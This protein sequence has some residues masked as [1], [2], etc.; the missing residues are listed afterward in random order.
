MSRS[1]SG[2]ERERAR[3]TVEV[4]AQMRKVFNWSLSDSCLA[5]LLTSRASISNSIHSTRHRQESIKRLTKRAPI[6][7]IPFNTQHP[8]DG[9]VIIND[10]H[11]TSVD[12]KAKREKEME[13]FTFPENNTTIK[14]NLSKLIFH[15]Y[16]PLIDK[17][18]YW[19]RCKSIISLTGG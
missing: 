17:S 10:S 6:Y 19:Q 3:D 4:V 11:V 9:F 14:K 2:G 12:M 5:W 15:N 13:V 1:R 16:L 18:K 7:R 8:I